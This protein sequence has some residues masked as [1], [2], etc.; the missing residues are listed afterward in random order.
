M[1]KLSKEIVEKQI[2]PE[3]VLQF[4]EGNFLRAFVD[5]QIDVMNEAGVFN[6]S[7]VVVQPI[8]QGLV[9]KL[10]QQDGLYTM[11]LNGYKDGSPVKE[12]RII[13]SI[14]RSINPY[15]NLEDYLALA[16]QK[17]LEF[18]FSNTTEAGIVFNENDR[19]E[20]ELPKSFPAKITAFLYQRFLHFDGDVNKGMTIIP[21]ELID[22][23]GDFLKK[24]VLQYA[25]LW[26]LPKA[27]TDWLEEANT[28]C[29]SLV[30]RIVPGYPK[31]KEESLKNELGY[32]DDLMV[33]G[34][35]YHQWVIEAPNSVRKSFPADKAVL[36]TL[37]V[38]DL[39]PYRTRKVKILN[40]THS[41]MTP[42]AYLAGIDTVKEAVEDKLVGSYIQ[43]LLFDEILKTIDF[44]EKEL[45]KFT[46]DVL[47][48]F[49][50]PYI[51]HFLINISLNSVAKFATRDLPTLLEYHSIKKE[52]PE[53]LAFA[54][55]ALILFYQGKRGEESIDLK[56]DEDVLS[57]FQEQWDSYD[58]SQ[59]K[60]SQM[61]G[62]V[63]AQEKW[64][65]EN[66]NTYV[67]LSEKIA[68]HLYKMEQEGVRKALIEL[69]GAEIDA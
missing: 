9:S 53:K 10:N 44:P 8:K 63:L 62:N 25:S 43:S 38:E 54:F 57:F 14:S 45:T 66:L 56:D 20:D 69:M 40:G 33:V 6:G 61:V 27:F 4:G 11:L 41:A 13:Q 15:E 2:Y 35:Y 46:E 55:A 24:Y 48:R 3:R 32:Q 5:W 39:N 49:R 26:K 50:N 12:K 42:V 30:D 28:F 17:D 65:G 67:G 37:Y 19:L 51:Q 64:W 36:N 47:D 18:I 31:D 34:E 16:K 22:R 52:I 59:Q 23:N 21:C 60:I 58:G 7:V 68:T 29:C 1:K